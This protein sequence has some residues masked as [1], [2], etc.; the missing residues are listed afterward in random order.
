MVATASVE[1]TG[2]LYTILLL[3]GLA[4]RARGNC[5]LHGVQTEGVQLRKIVVVFY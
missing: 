1:A 2:S 3:L 4:G 5:V